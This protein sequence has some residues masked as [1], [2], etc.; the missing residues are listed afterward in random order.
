M[1]GDYTAIGE[2]L[3]ALVEEGMVEKVREGQKCIYRLAEVDVEA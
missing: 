2:E 1:K 3:K